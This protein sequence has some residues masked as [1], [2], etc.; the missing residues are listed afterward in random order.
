MFLLPKMHKYA[1]LHG[2]KRSF[3]GAVTG[4]VMTPNVKD[5]ALRQGF[6]V[7]EPSGETFTITEPKGDYSPREW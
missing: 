7:V 5:Y 4:V 1:D 2:D 6:F 3:L